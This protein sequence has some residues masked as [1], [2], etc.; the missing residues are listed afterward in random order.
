MDEHALTRL[1]LRDVDEAL[2]R[3]QPGG[4]QP[5]ASTFDNRRVDGRSAARRRDELGV[6]GG[7]PREPRHAEHRV[8]DGER[9]TRTDGVHH[10]GDIPA[11]G[12][13]QARAGRGTQAAA[14]L[15]VDRV[16]A[17]RLD[18]H[19]DLRGP[20]FRQRPLL[21]LENLGRAERVLD[22]RAHGLPQRSSYH[23]WR[24]GAAGGSVPSGAR[25]VSA[26]RVPSITVGA[27]GR[28]SS[29]AESVGS[30]TNVP[31]ARGR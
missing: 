28:V 30:A 22:D 3:R 10:A 16:H 27:A 24:R 9:D 17:G 25:P 12:E 5:P 26:R 23:A 1:D 18:P 7:L 20:W 19:A 6:G 14:G 13:R 15:P 21:H 8:A 11:D 4:R 31:A 29:Q 2:P